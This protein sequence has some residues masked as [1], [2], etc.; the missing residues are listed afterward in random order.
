MVFPVCGSRGRRFPGYRFQCVECNQENLLETVSARLA[1]LGATNDLLVNSEWQSAPLREILV[2]EF[3]PYGLARFRLRGD[4][5]ECP[6][7]IA[8]VLAMMIHELTTNA[9]K[10]GALS[11]PHG[12]VV[13][14]WSLAAHRLTIDW[15]E[16]GGPKPTAPTR[17]GFGTKLIR[18]GVRQFDGSVARAAIWNA[19]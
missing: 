17:E 6:Y 4:D 11:S 8:V 13:V 14:Q 3:S 16:T 2:Q 1:A 15:V 10:Y 9:V 18:S 19:V 7:A 12:H 5:V